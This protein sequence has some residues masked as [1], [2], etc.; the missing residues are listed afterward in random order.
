[1][2][3]STNLHPEPEDISA[4]RGR[5]S[6]VVWLSLGTNPAYA[7]IFLDRAV[8]SALRAA[9]SDAEN[10]LP[11]PA[12]APCTFDACDDTCLADDSGRW[13][14]TY[15]GVLGGIEV[16]DVGTCLCQHHVTVQ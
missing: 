3:Q 9:L 12:T 7:N 16:D 10:L 13:T 14:C 15:A 11:P 1:M 2:Y 5:N 4:A 8:I 6:S